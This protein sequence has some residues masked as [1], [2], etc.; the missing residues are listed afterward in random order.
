MIK[1]FDFIEYLK[2]KIFTKSFNSYRWVEGIIYHI[3]KPNK[4]NVSNRLGKKNPS[5]KNASQSGTENYLIQYL[6]TNYAKTKKQKVIQFE[7]TVQV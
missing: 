6:K 4:T 3:I 2:K 5:T 7:T 1:H